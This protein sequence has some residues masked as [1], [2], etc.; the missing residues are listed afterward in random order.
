MP[1]QGGRGNGGNGGNGGRGRN[2][3][4]GRSSR[5]TNR[6]ASSTPK[7]V[8][9]K[10]QPHSNGTGDKKSATY[11]K[12]VEKI[13]HRVAKEFDNGIDIST[14]IKKLKMVDLDKEKP[15][16][17]VSTASPNSAADAENEGFAIIFKEEVGAFIKRKEAL[18]TNKA[19][20]YS[21][22]FENYCGGA[23]Q[24]RLK[25][26]PEFE[27]RIENHPIELLKTV[28]VLIHDPVRATYPFLSILDA[29]ERFIKVKQRDNEALT[30]YVDRVKEERNT[31]KNHLGKRWMDEFVKHTEEWKTA[32]DAYKK[33][34]CKDAAFE[35][36]TTMVMLKGADYGS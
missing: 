2:P 34:E 10:F 28:S 12:I 16:K 15:I 9:Y 33:N 29:F 19:K 4:R 23:M 21:L 26:H 1:T 35:S 24:A 13:V 27:S 32:P 31:I 36:F 3:G 11:G 14:S 22:I 20:A 8:E 17:D 25:E 7:S 30:D 18:R 6:N 5:T